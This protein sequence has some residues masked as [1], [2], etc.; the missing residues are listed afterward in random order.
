ML[1]ACDRLGLLVINEAFDVWTMEKNTHDYSQYFEENWEADMESFILRDR[2][3]PSIIMWSTGN[4]I[5]ERGG[6]SNGYMWTAKLANKVRE[7]D[8]TRPIINS[9]CSFFNGLDDEDMTEFAKS[10]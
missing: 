4:E 1:D 7:L 2:N 3:H 5:P 9:L 10:Y 6:M 8:P